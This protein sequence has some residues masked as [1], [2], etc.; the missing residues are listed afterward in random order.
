MP[1]GHLGQSIRKEYLIAEH[2]QSLPSEILGMG[3]C[4]AKIKAS[5]I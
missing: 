1:A 2:S 5:Q 3:G 4:G